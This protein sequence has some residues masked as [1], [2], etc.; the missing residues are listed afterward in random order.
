[1]TKTKIKDGY[2]AN[3]WDGKYWREAYGYLGSYYTSYKQAR[4]EINFLLREFPEKYQGW[5]IERIV[6][7]DKF[8]V[9]DAR[10]VV[11]AH[12]KDAPVWHLQEDR[13][14]E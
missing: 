5:A 14:V 12:S 4:F 8:R 2:T 1:M 6:L 3:L 7:E 9:R 10:V 13:E 11:L